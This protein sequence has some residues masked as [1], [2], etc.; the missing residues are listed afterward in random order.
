MITPILFRAAVVFLIFLL[1][2]STLFSR[3]LVSIATFPFDYLA[4]FSFALALIVSMCFCMCHNK[5]QLLDE[6]NAVCVCVAVTL[7]KG[8]KCHMAL[9]LRRLLIVLN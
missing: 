4:L 2:A 5:K 8:F 9:L 7:S 6:I 3:F 1:S